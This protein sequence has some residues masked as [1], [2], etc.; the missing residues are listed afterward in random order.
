MWDASCD[1]ATQ[2]SDETLS[3][4][5]GVFPTSRVLIDSPIGTFSPPPQV[6]KRHVDRWR[7]IPGLPNG[8]IE[9]RNP[10]LPCSARV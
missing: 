2:T 5:M 10:G 1:P 7:L 3:G 8:D 6:L 4:K 9:D